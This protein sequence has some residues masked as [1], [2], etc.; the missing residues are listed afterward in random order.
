MPGIGRPGGGRPYPDVVSETTPGAAEPG[1]GP[2]VRP[3]R[4]FLLALAAFFLLGA[5][6]AAALPV[7][8]TYD[9][10]QHVVRAYAVASGQWLPSGTATENT[11]HPSWRFRAPG[12]L[13]PGDYNCTWRPTRLPASCQR[14]AGGPQLTDASSMAGRYSPVYYLPVG[15]PLLAWPD[16]T[17]ILLARL[18]SALLAALLLA[19]AAAAAARLGRAAVAAVALVGTPMA[20]N[21]NGAVNPNGLEI[22]AG[23]LFFATMLALLR[24]DGLDR[25]ST[26]RLLAGA[27][28]AAFLLLT[29]RQLGP[30]LLAANLIG[31]LLVAR[32][33]RLRALVRSGAARAWLG[34]LG[35]AGAAVLIGWTLA[36]RIDAIPASPERAVHAGAGEVARYILRVRVPFYLH[37]I[38]GQFSYGETTISR[39]AIYWWYLVVGVVVIASL[40]RA[41]WRS[42]L[43]V[44]WLA[45]FCAALLIGLDAVLAGRVGWSQHGRYAL[46]TLVGVVL[47]AAAAE[48]AR[49]WLGAPLVAAGLVLAIVPVHGYALARVM[50]RFQNGINA[51]LDP[52][53]GSWLP[54]FGPVLPLALLGL[55]L[56]VL[57]AL[58]VAAGA[59]PAGANPAGAN[60][61]GANPAGANPAGATGPGAGSGPSPDDRIVRPVRP[62]GSDLTKEERPVSTTDAGSY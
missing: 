26:R 54:R 55:G 33:G 25:A 45:G 51:P 46:P 15:L 18:V 10:K 17:G 50:T 2:S 6:W 31:C 13:L 4:V 28:V 52:L 8:G 5:A 24:A 56:L 62:G 9:E 47:V 30:A 3:R 37:Q 16:G 59:N 61:A 42:W 44:G 11:G 23:V 19:A 39:W 48:P 53:H 7:N 32:P 38:V 41:G 20:M 29:V 40:L 49:R 34:G 1:R 36:S 12:S 58:P 27:G 14:P 21:L 35:L 22:A 60:P 57:V 43:A